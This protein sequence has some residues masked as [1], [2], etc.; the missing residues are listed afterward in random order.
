LSERW[1]DWMIWRTLPFLFLI[2]LWPIFNYVLQ[3]DHAF[4]RAFSGGEFLLISAMLLLSVSEYKQQ[5]EVITLEQGVL[6]TSQG[7]VMGSVLKIFAVLLVMMYIALRSDIASHNYFAMSPPPSKL[8][9]YAVFSLSISILV[10]LFSM[11]VYWRILDQLI[12]LEFERLGRS[13]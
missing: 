7:G 9:S 2:L 4:E 8:L 13:D 11:Y 3:L 1:L 10:F 6:Q 5:L 12:R